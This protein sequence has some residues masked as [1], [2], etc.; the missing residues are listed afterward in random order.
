MPKIQT[1]KKERKEQG[2]ETVQQLRALIALPEDKGSIPS[3]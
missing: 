1:I 3:N 2:L